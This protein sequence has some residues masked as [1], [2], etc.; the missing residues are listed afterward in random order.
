MYHKY[1]GN[2]VAGWNRLTQDL[3]DNG[4]YVTG[5]A[6]AA[7]TDGDGSISHAEYF[8]IPGGINP[9]IFRPEFVTPADITPAMALENP[10]TAI[11][12][13][14]QVLVAADDTLENEVK[15]FYFDIIHNTDSGWEFKNQLFYE[16]YTNLNEN[17]YGFSQFHDSFVIEDK[18]V[19]SKVFEGDSL[20][21]SIQL[22]PSIRHTDFKH[23]DDFV[24]EF[25]DRHDLT[26]PSTARDRRLLATRINNEF[27]TYFVVDYTYLGLGAL[28]DF[29]WESGLSILLGARYDTIDV[30][31]TSVDARLLAP[32]GADIRETD[33]QDGVS[34]AIGPIIPYVTVSEQSTIIAGQ[35]RANRWARGSCGQLV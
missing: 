6:Q 31:S 34:W 21:T 15:T 3:I 13:G 35:G 33:T 10:G 8:A 27:T 4:T 28:A 17:A 20:T 16:G 26:G 11:L 19:I 1:D 22:S 23:G 18:F 7:D 25:F 29:T 2:Q 32:T 14:S 5:L 24:N 30:T 9:F 12:D